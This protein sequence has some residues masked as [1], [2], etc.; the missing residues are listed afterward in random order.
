MRDTDEDTSAG[1]AVGQTV[2]QAEEAEAEITIGLVG[3]YRHH[4]VVRAAGTLSEL[5]D[6]PQLFTLCGAVTAWGL[7]TGDRRL[8]ACGGRMLAS[9]LLATWT[10]TAVKKLVART[11]PN[12][13][14]DHGVHEAGLMGPDKGPWNSFPS[15]HT[16]GSLAVARAWARRYP[17]MRAPAYAWAASVAAAQIPR[18][19]HYPSDVA[20]GA[21]I[22]LAAEAAADRLLTAAGV[23]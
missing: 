2:G 19:A 18:C 20:A 13:L 3:R 10:K 8:A 17:S 4:P 6:Q 16:A 7:A 23:P 15:G 12:M 14:T 1:A 9:F 5:A 21:A 11:R 22:G